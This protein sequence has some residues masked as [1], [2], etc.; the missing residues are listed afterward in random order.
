M[1]GWRRDRPLADLLLGT[2]IDPPD[3]A[4]LCR[5]D[6]GSSRT[7]RC[8]LQHADCAETIGPTGVWDLMT[9]FLPA[10]VGYLLLFAA[11]YA[12]FGVQS[13]YLPLLLQAP[14]LRAEAIGIVLAAGTGIR[15]SARSK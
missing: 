5:A 14:G 12:G 13:P 3:S 9:P 11:L 8:P 7:Q 15:L 1:T 10:L 6:I 2:G 4:I